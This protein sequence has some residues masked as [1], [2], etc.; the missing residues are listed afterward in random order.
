MPESGRSNHDGPIEIILVHG[1]LFRMRWWK[2]PPRE[3]EVRQ[4]FPWTDPNSKSTLAA[5]LQS[6]RDQLP[7]LKL[8]AFP[9]KGSN[10]SRARREAAECLARMLRDNPERKKILVTHSHGGN[11]ALQALQQPSAQDSVLGVV[12]MA[13]PFLQ[14]LPRDPRGFLFLR[15][16]GIVGLEGVCWFLRLFALSATV[17]G[18]IG[19]A[20]KLLGGVME[21]LSWCVILGLLLGGP[22]V[23]LLSRWVDALLGLRGEREAAEAARKVQRAALGRHQTPLDKPCLCIHAA[24]DEAGAWLQVWAAVTMLP[25]ALLNRVLASLGVLLIAV[26]AYPRVAWPLEGREASDVLIRIGLSAALSLVIA[27]IVYFALAFGATALA[28]LFERLPFTF[29]SSAHHRGLTHTTVSLTPIYARDV[30][31]KAFTG[32]SLLAHSIHAS[33]EVREEVV[34][35][36]RRRIEQW[37]RRDGDGS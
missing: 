22:P 26:I 34:Q 27:C 13:T 31:F 8:S 9:W 16:I 23:W 20:Q 1:T 7:P 18:V 28:N 17:L 32:V 36:V 10:S 21:E 19:L 12:C 33:K 37:R 24:G 5:E 3:E 30:T 35:W 6:L 2:G 14:P 15:L 25:Y 11:V 29:G 4:L